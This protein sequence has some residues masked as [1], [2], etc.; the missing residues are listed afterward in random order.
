MKIQQIMTKPV[1][2]IPPTC[3]LRDAARKMRDLNVGALPVGENDRL[4]GMLT[5]R[6]IAIKGTAEGLNP[7]TTDVR[8][9]VSSP[10]IYCY[11][12]QDVE[13]AARLMEVKQIRRLVVLNRQKRL[14][15]ILSLG[16]IAT[17]TGNEALSGEALE[18]IS[19]PQKIIAA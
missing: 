10:I 18:K 1:H 3:T 5:D 16:D 11:E 12:D 17:R 8:A 15:G 4:L 19:E 9:L 6:D 13:E 14:V 7:E 2:F